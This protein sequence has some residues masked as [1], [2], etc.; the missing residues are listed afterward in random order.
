VDFVFMAGEVVVV[1][2]PEPTAF[3]DAYAMVKVVSMEKPELSV[4]IIV[5]MARNGNEAEVIAGKFNEIV[6]RF[7]GK[8]I[9]YRGSI[10]KDSIVSESIMRQTPLAVY[11]PKSSPMQSIREIARNFLGLEKTK[12]NRLFNR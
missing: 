3:A 1:M 2:T 5:N 9:Q 12:R 6:Q 7:L 11:A 10:L 4:G 8:S